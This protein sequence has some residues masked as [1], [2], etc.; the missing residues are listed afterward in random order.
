VPAQALRPALLIAAAAALAAGIGLVLAGR[1]GGPAAAP[2]KKPDVIVLVFDEFLG[3]ALLGRDG[4]IDAVRY[5]NF[6]SLADDG[7]WFPNAFSSYDSTSKGTPLILDGKKP[8]LHKLPTRRGHPRSIYDLFGR[9][10]YRFVNSEA[11]TALCPRRYCRNA[12]ARPPKILAQLAGGRQKRFERFVARIKRRRKP[13]FYFQHVLLPH[14]PYNY[15]PSGRRTREGGGD[16]VRGMNSPLGFHD[17]FLMQHNYQRYLLQQG[18]V[19][20]ELGKLL[21]RLK[22]QGMYEDTM[23]VITADQ[24]IALSEVGTSDRRKVSERNVDEVASV[25]MFIKRA[26]QSEG[27]TERAYMRTLDVTPTIADILDLRLPYRADGRSAFSRAVK[28][29][30]SVFLMTRYFERVIRISARRYEAR[31]ARNVR[32]RTD[33]FGAGA[34][35]L[36]KGIGPNRSLLGRRLADLAL[37][38]PSEVGGSVRGAGQLRTVDRSAGVV[39]TQIVGDV[40]GGGRGE[41]RDLA[42]AVNGRIEA[43]GRSWYLKGSRTEHFAVNVPESSLREGRNSVEVFELDRRKRLRLLVRVA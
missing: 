16:Q 28:A 37:G 34:E 25:P 42:V 31:R 6:A 19:D 23:I 17:R 26:G 9:R 35:S 12:P 38:K 15:L 21:G 40:E 20:H 29:R 32:R 18:F 36:F 43:V 8:L 30:R 24:A 14:V 3:D 5:P 41:K 10:G 4:R 33:W 2:P 1:N 27:R 22:S 39:P 11:A 7:H 13:T